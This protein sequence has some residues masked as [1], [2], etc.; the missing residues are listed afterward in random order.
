MVFPL[1][2]L[3]ASSCSLVLLVFLSLVI[4]CN[5]FKMRRRRKAPENGLPAGSGN[6]VK[7]N[8]SSVFAKAQTMQDIG[9]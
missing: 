2:M 6:E 3:A 9:F 7:I 5:Q 8:V 4:S 1:P